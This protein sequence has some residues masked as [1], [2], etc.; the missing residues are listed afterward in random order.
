MSHPLATAD[1]NSGH[2]PS[3]TSLP[4]TSQPH[5]ETTLR[6]PSP[7]HQASS[8]SPA[9][10]TPDSCNPRFIHNGAVCSYNG[11]IFDK[12]QDSALYTGIHKYRF[13]ENGKGRGI[14]GR[15]SHAVAAS[16]LHFNTKK[17]RRDTA[18][19]DHYSEFNGSSIGG[20]SSH[21]HPQSRRRGHSS[22]ASTGARSGIKAPP[23]RAGIAPTSGDADSS[24]WAKNLRA[25]T[26]YPTSHKLLTKEGHCTKLY[27]DTSHL[28]VG[29]P[30]GP[31]P[32]PSHP[33]SSQAL[34]HT[35]YVAA[36]FNEYMAVETPK[37]RTHS[38]PSHPHFTNEIH[39][40]SP[41]R[42]THL[43]DKLSNKTPLR[44]D[45]PNT[46]SATR[47]SDLPG[48][49][50]IRPT[51]LHSP[52]STA[53]VAATRS[54]GTGH[55]AMGGGATASSFPPPTASGL[56]IQ[57]EMW[58]MDDDGNM[59]LDYE[60]MLEEARKVEALHA[61]RAR[62][63]GEIAAPPMV[64]SQQAGTTVAEHSPTKTL[65]AVAAA[66]TNVEGG[67]NAFSNVATPLNSSSNQ[68]VTPPPKVMVLTNKATLLGYTRETGTNTTPVLEIL[69]RTKEE[70]EREALSEYYK[71]AAVVRIG[72]QFQD[73]P[74]LPI[75]SS[76][77]VLLQDGRTITTLPINP[78]PYMVDERQLRLEAALAAEEEEQKRLLDDLARAELSR[79]EEM[80]RQH[81]MNAWQSLQPQ[82]LTMEEFVKPN[83][84]HSTF[85]DIDQPSQL[86]HRQPAL[87]ASSI[88]PVHT[89]TST[90][91]IEPLEHNSAAFNSQSVVAP[92][93]AHRTPNRHGEVGV[94]MSELMRGSLA[95]STAAGYPTNT[96]KHPFTNPQ[97]IIPPEV[98]AH[99]THQQQTQGSVS[100]GVSA[101]YPSADVGVGVT[102]S[103]P[104]LSTMSGKNTSANNPPSFTVSAAEQKTLFS[105]SGA[106]PSHH[107]NTSLNQSSFQGRP[108]PHEGILSALSKRGSLVDSQVQSSQRNL[109]FVGGTSQSV[110]VGSSSFQNVRQPPPPSQAPST[111]TVTDDTNRRTFASVA[112]EEQ[113]ISSPLHKYSTTQP[114]SPVIV[115]GRPHQEPLLH[116]TSSAH[117]RSASLG[118]KRVDSLPSVV[119]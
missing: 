88:I 16:E 62:R 57:Y 98:A 58:K 64:A 84:S 56:Y 2:L 83:P 82:P 80:Q 90:P 107:Q 6:T 33:P 112:E 63:I 117:I 106:H 59:S 24:L 66:A 44:H 45:S 91:V 4:T 43:E 5:T 77:N 76:Q 3:A 8:S 18:T 26:H 19:D 104:W 25:Q 50:M 109:A 30:A 23:S 86:T 17:G 52:S 38:S 10:L 108:H 27:R 34:H 41:Q 21:H 71:N 99:Y 113:M 35:T 29:V 95:A 55:T 97:S 102:P 13:D 40:Y 47:T 42:P 65:T 46:R 68:N 74:M 69:K 116:N 87:P 103:A 118:A 79:R 93:N 11:T 39:P 67:T 110:P 12:L 70:R 100:R 53:S 15:D 20:A 36:P 114:G 89:S 94:T 85:P 92:P 78:N 75:N 60:R 49:A 81:A 1:Y 115:S 54:Q 72:P 9:I 28:G 31:P 37:Q 96:T 7:K 22:G 48:A 61:L 51:Q 73:Q 105:S 111:R 101:R 14:A 32:P 119:Q